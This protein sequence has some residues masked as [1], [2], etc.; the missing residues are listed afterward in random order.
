MN[1]ELVLLLILV[2][3]SGFFSS[4]ELAYVVANKIKIELRARKNFLD[5]KNAQYFMEHPQL[6]YSTILISNNI[7]NIAFASLSTIFLYKVFQFG[8]ITI[9]II[10]STAILI[11]GELIPKFVARELP[12]RLIMTVALPLR[13]IAFIL[14]P[15]VYVTSSIS[16]FISRSANLNEEN[17]AFLFGKDDLQHLI[18]E[19]TDMGVIDEIESDIISKVLDMGEQKIY[20]AMTPRTDVVGIEVKSTVG[21]AIKIFVESGY[22]KIPVYEDSL[23]NIKGFIH[24]YD[25]F[26]K[27]EDLH[28]VIRPIN[29]VPDTKKSLEMLNE[30]LE[31]Q[32]SIAIVV[33]EF[34]GTAGIVTVEDIIEE[35]FGEIRDEYDAEEEVC[36]KIDEHTYIISGKVEIDYINEQFELD[37]PLGDYETIAGLITSKIGRIPER[38][39]TYIIDDKFKALIIRADIRRIE[40]IKLFIAEEK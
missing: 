5:A 10:S 15:L 34:G 21:E 30:F 32:V 40:L 24:A 38:G 23:D 17:Y 27:P 37:M 22:S 26:K 35:M 11:F 8:D 18:T 19:S 25:M 36:R 4:S 13:G 39:K 9:L 2:I 6:F 7:V 29:F 1:S 31:K 12:D 3:L 33:D 16:T 14:Y 28:K 20:A